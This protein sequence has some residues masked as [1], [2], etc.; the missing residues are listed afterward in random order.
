M[1][2][3]SSATNELAVDQAPEKTK[4]AALED[5]DKKHD[6]PASDEQDGDDDYDYE[7][8]EMML[9]AFEQADE[10]EVSESDDGAG[11]SDDV[12]EFSKSTEQGCPEIQEAPQS[13]AN[14][15][16][17]TSGTSS[18]LPEAPR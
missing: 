11:G 13:E 4:L 3:F 7:L 10:D 18:Q 6:Y 14:I 8:E 16:G 5:T 9:A 1:A 15:D 2:G 17:G 12:G